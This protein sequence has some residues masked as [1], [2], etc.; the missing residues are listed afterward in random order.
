MT[1]AGCYTSFNTRH[2]YILL[3]IR[4]KLF[5][6]LNIAGSNQSCT[7][8]L[9]FHFLRFAEEAV[10]LFGKISFQFAGS[11]NAETFFDGTSCFHF[12]H[13]ASLS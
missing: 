4:Q 10:S 9:S 6:N 3:Q 8:S 1:S 12:W 13:F 2:L 7:A 5:N 11:G